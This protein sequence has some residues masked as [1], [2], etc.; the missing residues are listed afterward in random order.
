[1]GAAGCERR[2]A[3]LSFLQTLNAATET[4]ESVAQLQIIPRTQ[5]LIVA[6]SPQNTL[7]EDGQAENRDRIARKRIILAVSSKNGRLRSL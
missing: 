2:Q 1:M 5:R 4:M 7:S 6:A 3:W